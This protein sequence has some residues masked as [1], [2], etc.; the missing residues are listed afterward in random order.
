M[1]SLIKKILK[2]VHRTEDELPFK[3]NKKGEKEHSKNSLTKGQNKRQKN[4]NIQLRK[5]Q[6]LQ[7]ELLN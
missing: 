2:K 3:Q 6:Y 1:A 5:A 7:Q 4:T